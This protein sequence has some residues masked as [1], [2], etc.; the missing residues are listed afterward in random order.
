MNILSSDRIKLAS[1]HFTKRADDPNWLQRMLVNSGLVEAPPPPPPEGPMKDVLGG[2]AAGSGLG[3]GAAYGAH[4]A[5]RHFGGE[6]LRLRNNFTEQR[7]LA[8][9]LGAG[10]DEARS[11]GRHVP[12]QAEARLQAIQQMLS[13]GHGPLGI[14]DMLSKSRLWKNIRGKSLMFGIP[15]L[16]AA[17]ALTGGLLH[18][19]TP[20]KP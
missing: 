15:G 7:Q 5:E 20:Q 4:G 19:D 10:I 1:Y 14:N 16:A 18:K 3:L 8:R 11:L 17:G 12:P 13:S 9:S 2:A 6:A